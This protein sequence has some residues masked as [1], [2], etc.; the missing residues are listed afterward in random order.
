MFLFLLE[1]PSIVVKLIVTAD[2]LSKKGSLIK[3]NFFQSLIKMN[4]FQSLLKIKDLHGILDALI[5]A[6]VV[7]PIKEIQSGIFLARVL[8]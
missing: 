3:M 6:K 4:F 1:N 2:R 5:E 8:I 7:E